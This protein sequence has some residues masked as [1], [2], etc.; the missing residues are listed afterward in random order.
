MRKLLK[1]TVVYLCMLL[2]FPCIFLAWAE[3]KLGEKEEVFSFFAQFFS[4]IPGKTGS[5]I[6][7]AYYKGT[8][9][10]GTT[11]FFMA[12]GSFFSH[13]NV[14]LEDNVNIGAYCII[15]CTHIGRDVMLASKASVP[16]GKDQHVAENGG[17][18]RKLNLQVVKIGERTWVG[19]GAIVMNDVG[20]DCVVSAG[21]VVTKIIPSKTMAIG[22][23][24]RI[25]KREHYGP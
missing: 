3:K 14:V 13:R 25:L 12:F 2:I 16:S 17:V 8:L 24:C 18:S 7:V 19:E 10:Q 6:R 9:K 5:Y 22:N 23:P 21:T 11:N 4:L 15:G 1:E 20:D